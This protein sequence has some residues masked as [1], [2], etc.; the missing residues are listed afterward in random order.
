[1][2]TVPLIH[3]QPI[4]NIPEDRKDGRDLLLWDT[5]GASVASWSGTG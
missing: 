5:M 2:I 3:W 1:M 4:D